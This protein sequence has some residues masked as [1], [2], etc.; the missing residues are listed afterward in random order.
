MHDEPGA[1]AAADV[2]GCAA[3]KRPRRSG[4]T[5]AAVFTLPEPA[6]GRRRNGKGANI[7]EKTMDGMGADAGHAGGSAAGDGPGGRERRRSSG[8]GGPA[9]GGA[10]GR[11]GRQHL[12]RGPVEGLPQQRRQPG[13][14]GCRNAPDGG[15][16]GPSLEKRRKPQ[17][18]VGRRIPP[19][20]GGRGSGVH[21]RHR[22]LPHRQCRWGHQGARRHDSFQRRLGQRAPGLRRGQDLRSS[23]GWPGPGL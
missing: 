12:V 11:A 9:G 18:R 22:H 5:A 7:H 4:R 20:A 8:A 1:S 21:C 10:G 17:R 15:G 13:R 14:D 2:L 16:S 23:A 3:E 6:A 19:A